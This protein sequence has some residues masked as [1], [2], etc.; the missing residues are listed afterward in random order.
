MQRRLEMEEEFRKARTQREN[1]LLWMMILTDLNHCGYNYSLL[2]MM[3][4]WQMQ[5]HL[6]HNIV[7]SGYGY[8]TSWPYYQPM[9]QVYGGSIG[10]TD[11][12]VC[13]YAF[14]IF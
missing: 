5:S 8:D 10:N 13:T 1:D 2:D 14:I 11:I 3:W 7:S 4:F 6:Y 12:L 9:H